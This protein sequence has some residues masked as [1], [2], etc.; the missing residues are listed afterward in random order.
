VAALVLSAAAVCAV[1][2]PAL[3]RTDAGIAAVTLHHHH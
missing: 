1:T 3:S 2:V